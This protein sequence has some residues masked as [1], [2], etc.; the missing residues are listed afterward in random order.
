V[1]ILKENLLGL[2]KL[3]FNWQMGKHFAI[4]FNERENIALL[5][6][7]HGHIKQK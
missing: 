7:R 6:C 4:K 3:I 1:Q 2:Y 5:R